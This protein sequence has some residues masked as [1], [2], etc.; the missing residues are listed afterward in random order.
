MVF[1]TSAKNTKDSR[2]VASTKPAYEPPSWYDKI[3]EA[4]ESDPDCLSGPSPLFLNMIMSC[5]QSALE[6]KDRTKRPLLALAR[7]RVEWFK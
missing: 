2:V 3:A 4:M 7:E 5:T 6:S 1:W